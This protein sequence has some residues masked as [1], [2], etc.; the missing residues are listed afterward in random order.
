MLQ[1][2]LSLLEQNSLLFTLCML[3]G[4]KDYNAVLTITNY[5]IDIYAPNDK[6][7]E[8]INKVPKELASHLL[9]ISSYAMKNSLPR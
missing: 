4:K 7:M 1:K 9:T 2:D 3:V 8:A 5:I 6:T